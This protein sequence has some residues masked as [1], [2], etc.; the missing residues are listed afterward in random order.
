M[1][2]VLGSAFS[3][4]LNYITQILFIGRLMLVFDFQFGLK[5]N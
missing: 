3:N 1:F 5:V 4:A 2:L